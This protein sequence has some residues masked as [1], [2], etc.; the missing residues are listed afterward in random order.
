MVLSNIDIQAALDDGSLVIRPEPSPR[1][2][3][4][5]GDKCP[6]QISAVDLT[7]GSDLAWLKAD[8]PIAIDL[9]R[10]GFNRLFASNCVRKTLDR[11]DVFVLKP[12]QLV[13]GRTHEHV[14]LPI[15]DQGPWLA[16]RV[17][18]RSSY[19]RCGLLV[20]FTAPTIHSGFAGTIT[21]EIMNF[22]PYSLSLSPG[23]PICQLIV[24]QVSGRPFRRDSQFQGQA[25]PTGGRR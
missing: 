18:G 3:A 17:E 12:G 20:H 14:E 25:E 16:A 6:F 19:A 21:L 23:T 22:G 4:A 9:R 24:E 8:M 11:D 13:L 7:L 15:R 1:R 5:D 10:G 2:P